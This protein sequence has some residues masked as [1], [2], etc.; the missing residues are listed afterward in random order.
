MHHHGEMTLVRT[1]TPDD[2]AA[3]R[4]VARSAGERFRAVA[5][6]RIARCADDPPP[7]DENLL[8]L[9]DGGRLLVADDDGGEVVGFVVLDVVDGRA[10]VDEISVA[11]GF[12][13]RGHGIAL[14]DAVDRW[15][16]AHRL[17]GV[18]LTTFRDVPWNRPYYE[19]RGFR[20]LDGSEL[21]PGLR[22][23]MAHEAELGLAPQLRVAMARP[24]ARGGDVDP[25]P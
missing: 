6:E 12:Q 18:T 2:V 17:D 14:L 19:R 23:V 21:T 16:A 25:L 7:R 1:A 3:V 8:A 4:E 5:D 22:R 15:S 20:V 9:V 13:G 11:T 24:R 10:H